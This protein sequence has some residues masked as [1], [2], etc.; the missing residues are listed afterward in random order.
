M[1]SPD[2]ADSSL[3]LPREFSELE[4][5]SN[6]LLRLRLGRELCESL[7]RFDDDDFPLLRPGRTEGRCVIVSGAVER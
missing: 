1:R 4:D 2:D 6:F 7:I 5:P 3:S